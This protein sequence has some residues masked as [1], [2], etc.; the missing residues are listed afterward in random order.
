VLVQHIQPTVA[1]VRAQPIVGGHINFRLQTID[2]TTFG[3]DDKPSDSSCNLI[4]HLQ[5]DM[6]NRLDITNCYSSE[7]IRVLLEPIDCSFQAVFECDI[8]GPAELVSSALGI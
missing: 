8:W 6:G 5:S 4:L 1:A 2:R 3:S 7:S